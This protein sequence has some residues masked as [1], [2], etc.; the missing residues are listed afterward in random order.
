MRRLPKHG[1][2]ENAAKRVGKFYKSVGTFLTYRHVD[3]DKDKWADVNKYLP[4][5]YDMCY[6]KGE[7]AIL[8][9]WY[10]GIG[11]DGHRIKP[12]F[13]VLFWKLNYDAL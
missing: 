10:N 11:W 13:K 3:F 7:N 1:Q 6:C 12:D 5:E 8:P 4:I 2:N 9:G